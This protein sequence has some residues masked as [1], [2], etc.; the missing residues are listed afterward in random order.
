MEKYRITLRGIWHADS[1]IASETATTVH[2]ALA[3]ADQRDIQKYVHPAFNAMHASP[4]SGPS[5]EKERDEGISAVTSALTDALANDSNAVIV[6]GHQPLMSVLAGT[7]VRRRVPWLTSTAPLTR[8]EV[9][10]KATR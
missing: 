5:Y 4:F 8:G 2:D 9:A 6:I 1:E 3:A 7:L 10:C